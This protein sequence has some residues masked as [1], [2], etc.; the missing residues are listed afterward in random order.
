V[1]TPPHGLSSSPM[2]TDRLKGN[3]TEYAAY[4]HTQGNQWSHYFGIPMI[5]MTLLGLLARITL[6]PTDLGMLFL[7]ASL[8]WCLYL[9][10]KIS[11]PYSFVIL[12]LYFI[13]RT[14]SLEIN[15]VIFVLGWV[16]Q[17]IGHYVYE[18]K[19]PAFLT[20]IKH[21]LIGPLWIFAKLTGY[22]KTPT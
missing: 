21:V 16:I 13:G 14:L 22:G 9:D 10:W 15:G 5:A 12:G 19:S 7:S 6:G 11:V 2:I 20:N 1:H 3:F 17:G 18:K 8:L 4:H